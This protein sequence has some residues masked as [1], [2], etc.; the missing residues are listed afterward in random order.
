MNCRTR[1]LRSTANGVERT[2]SH[3][4]A[5]TK[6]I[7]SRNPISGES[8]IAEPMMPTPCQTTAP[9]PAF[10]IPA[11]IRPP[12]RAWLLL[13]GMPSRHVVTFQTIAPMRAP[14]TTRGSTMLAWTTP[15]PIV[16]ATCKPK[17]VKAMKLKNDAHSTAVNGRRTRVATTVAMEL[18]LSCN[19]FRKSNSKAVATRPTRT[20]MPTVE[21][22]MS[23]DP[24]PARLRCRR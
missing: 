18:A 14:N 3:D 15:L 6:V 17:T 7:A 4:V 9:G 10:A 24:R 16:A 12:T 21:T 13:E 20:G 8:T 11:P 23:A 22:F 19:P 2:D 5:S 1:N